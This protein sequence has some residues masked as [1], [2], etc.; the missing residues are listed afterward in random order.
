MGRRDRDLRDLARAC[1]ARARVTL[2]SARPVEEA[3]H[4]H[5]WVHGQAR[6]EHSV[7]P[8]AREPIVAMK[9]HAPLAR[10]RSRSFRIV[11][12]PSE[13]GP[14]LGGRAPEG[15]VEGPP[16]DGAS[17]LL[18][19]PLASDPALELSVFLRGDVWDAI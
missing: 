17:Y 16:L 18:T 10:T 9:L 15:I 5:P 4:E 13:E 1:P 8:A 19:I 6:G 12:G 14:R 3:A 2:T 7:H 11:D